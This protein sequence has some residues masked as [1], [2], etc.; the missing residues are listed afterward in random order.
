MLLPFFLLPLLGLA[1]ALALTG[2]VFTGISLFVAAIGFRFLVRASGR[3]FVLSR[4]L[5]DPQF[6]AQARAAGVIQSRDSS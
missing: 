1:V 4:S 6:Y 2:Y 5:Q 3:S